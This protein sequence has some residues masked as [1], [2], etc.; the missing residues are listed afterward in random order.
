ME[1][2]DRIARYET[3]L[4]AAEQKLEVWLEAACTEGATP[5]DLRLLGSATTILSRIIDIRRKLTD[6]KTHE[7]EDESSSHLSAA[8]EEIFAILAD[9]AAADAEE[10]DEDPM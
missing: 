3:W 5:G 6:W 4:E 9:G 7:P 8:G 1:L 10:M 2:P